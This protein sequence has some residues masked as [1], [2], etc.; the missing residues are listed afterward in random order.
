MFANKFIYSTYQL[1]LLIA[2]KRKHFVPVYYAA[3]SAF[4]TKDN[5]G[6]YAIGTL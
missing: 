2:G 3:I 6:Y 4:P 1:N 5:W